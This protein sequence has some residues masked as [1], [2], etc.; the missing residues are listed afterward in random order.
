VRRVK[1]DRGA[2][3]VLVAILAVVLF[4]FAALVIDVGALYHERRQL[5][6]GA[7]AGAF[8]VGQACAG[9]DCGAFT[10]DADQ[11]ADDNALDLA[12]R[13]P[14]N[15][16]CGTE[17]AGLP[18]CVDPPTGLS[19]NGYVRVTT[20]TEQP[21]GSSLLPPFLA[22]VIDPDYAGTDVQAQATV[23]WGTPSGI[24]AELALTFSTC[25][26]D[27]LTKDAEGK[28]V[29][30]DEEN[31]D[32]TLER[33]IY[34]HD[35]TEASS[36]PGGPSGSDLPGGFGWLDA[37]A[38]CTATV[39]DGWAGDD[40]GAS[41]SKECKAA[42][43]AALGKV[44]L[45]PVFDAVNGLTGTNGEYHIVSYVGFLL[46]GWNFPGTQQPSAYMTTTPNPCASSQ[47]CLSGFFV[48]VT[49]PAT[50]EVG[51]GPDMGVQVTQLVY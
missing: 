10:S 14:T 13:I 24:D 45:I 29:L 50:G 38:D 48:E 46:T 5:Q 33:V 49:A 40:T 15:G 23:I 30:A 28:T 44:V 27:K 35:T 2:V 16:V 11:F 51:D 39:D 34:F 25:E 18:A 41:A 9:G 8:A 21:D 31:P 12:A 42:L 47:T 3:A 37:D 20:R 32:P 36:C 19:G 7:D 17:S 22:Q 6:V 43:E 4:G 26:Y 1:E